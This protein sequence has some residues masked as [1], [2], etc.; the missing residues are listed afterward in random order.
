MLVWN[1]SEDKTF[2]DACIHELTTNG[3]EGFGLKANS[4]K[5]IREKLINEHG[6]EVDQKQMRNQFDYY[7]SKYVAWVKLKSKTDNLYDPIKINLI[8][9]MNNGRNRGR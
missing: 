8:S 5:T 6:K 4:W 2:L 9:L 7:K 1:E 3:R